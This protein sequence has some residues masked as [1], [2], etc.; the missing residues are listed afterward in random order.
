MGDMISM[1]VLEAIVLVGVGGTIG[2]LGVISLGIK[3][4][5][6]H[7][8]FPA[9]TNDVI[10]RA[11]RRATRVG[12]RRPNPAHDARSNPKSTPPV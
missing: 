2:G 8:R 3:R 11:A 1:H 4:D 6:R 9:D 7:G 5:D 12:A 10:A